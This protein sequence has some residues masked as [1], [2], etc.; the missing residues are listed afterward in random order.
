MHLSLNGIPL[1]TIY[2]V[3]PTSWLTRWYFINVDWVNCVGWLFTQAA[4]LAEHW[5]F[6]PKFLDSIPSVD[7][8]H[9][10]KKTLNRISISAL[11]NDRHSVFKKEKWLF[12]I[13]EFKKSSKLA[14]LDCIHLTI[15]IKFFIYFH[16]YKF[17]YIIVYYLL[18]FNN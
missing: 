8:F 9:T 2:S 6:N 13:S 11:Y 18:N 15:W 7:A 17:N 3:Q 16:K 10:I 12:G 1:P 5:K 4:Q 14:T